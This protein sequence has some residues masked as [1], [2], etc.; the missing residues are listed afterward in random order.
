MHTESMRIRRK[1]W[2]TQTTGLS[3][4]TI[5][6]LEK[7]GDFPQR[8]LLGKAAVGWIEGEVLGWLETRRTNVAGGRAA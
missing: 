3:Q 8:L 2:V 6:R 5:R 1:P 4:S 7:A